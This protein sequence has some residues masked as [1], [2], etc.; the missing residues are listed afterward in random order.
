MRRRNVAENAG[1]IY[2]KDP[3]APKP[4][5]SCFIFR[6]PGTLLTAAHCVRD[7]DAKNLRITLPFSRAE[8]A[9]D[10]A[11]LVVHSKADVAVLYVKGVDELHVTWP[12]TDI[13]DDQVLG[14]NF[15][16]FGYPETPFAEDRQDVTPRYFQGYIQRFLPHS[17]RMGYSYFCG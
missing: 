7:F 3:D 1:I 9:F 13:F 10:V 6:N 2:S 8:G 14:E 12:H 17:S 4:L 16:V 5:G 11:D 15:S